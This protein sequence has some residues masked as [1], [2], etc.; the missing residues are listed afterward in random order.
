VV[1]SPFVKSGYVSHVATDHMAGLKFVG[2]RFNL[3]PL[4]ARDGGVNACDVSDFFNYWNPPWTS[5]RQN[6]PSDPPGNWVDGLP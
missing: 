4:A 3:Q 1:I 2:K 5:P 6:P